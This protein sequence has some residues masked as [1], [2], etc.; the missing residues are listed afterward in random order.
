MNKHQPDPQLES[1]F[2]EAGSWADDRSVQN[3]RSR[4]VAWIIAGVATTIA[5]LEAI[6]LAGLA[7]LKTVVPMTVLVDRQTGHVTTL[8]P[9]QPVRLAPDAALSRSMLAQYVTARESIDRATIATDY[10][11][12][13]LWSGE[14]AK[15]SYFAQM[16]PGSPDNPLARL[17]RQVSVQARIRS[18]SI[19]ENGQALVR[20]DLVQRNDV[21]GE[22]RAAPYVSVLR[23]RFRD[24]PLAE[25][26]RFI[27][28]LGFEVT[29]YRKDPE[30]A[31][32]AA[33][34]VPQQ[35]NVAPVP[36]PTA[37]DSEVLQ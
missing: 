31:P 7:P 35:Q 18:V 20:Y 22:S 14:A 34:A 23:Y 37:P 25:S 5:A 15:A 17:P 28:P 16:K 11:K 3:A 1:Y 33:D 32:P 30:A 21:G 2:R 10:R 12:V 9:S 6:A 8:D 26:D 36:N 19:M 24:R 29:R 27:N 13:A 4:R